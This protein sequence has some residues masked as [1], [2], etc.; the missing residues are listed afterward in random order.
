[1][2]KLIQTKVHGLR[3]KMIALLL[4]LEPMVKVAGVHFLKLLAF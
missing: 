4:T 2:K 3:K 1:M